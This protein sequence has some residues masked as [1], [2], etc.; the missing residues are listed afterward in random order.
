MAAICLWRSASLTSLIEVVGLVERIERQVRWIDGLIRR[1]NGRIEAGWKGLVGRID[2]LVKGLVGRIDREDGWM[3]IDRLRNWVVSQV[4]RMGRD[5]PIH[6][7]QSQKQIVTAKGCL[8]RTKPVRRG[9]DKGKQSFRLVIS[10]G[11]GWHT[12]TLTAH[13]TTAQ[14]LQI[15]LHIY[16]SR[17]LRHGGKK[18][19]AGRYETEY[20]RL[21]DLARTGA[22]QSHFR[23]EMSSVFQYLVQKMCEV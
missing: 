17:L 23:I 8:Q 19:R 1:G 16:A 21:D 14:P 20:F 11:R 22:G 2:R 18:P 12:H 10:S 6:D 15:V 9:Q 13:G 3:S 4:S 7:L 5:I